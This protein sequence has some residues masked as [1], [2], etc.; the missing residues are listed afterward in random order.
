[1]L[2]ILFQDS[3]AYRSVLHTIARGREGAD[4]GRYGG[5]ASYF[6]LTHLIDKEKTTMTGEYK[7]KKKAGQLLKGRRIMPV[8]DKRQDTA[9]LLRSWRCTTHSPTLKGRHCGDG[10]PASNE[11]RPTSDEDLS[12]PLPVID[13]QGKHDVLPT[14]HDSSRRRQGDLRN[15][16]DILTVSHKSKDEAIHNN[17]SDII[18]TSLPGIFITEATSATF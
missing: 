13:S 5:R 11:A 1:M 12:S 2:M 14:L 16:P 7:R 9:R 6:Q 10:R 4:S 3:L 18:K 8:M 17:K 15:F